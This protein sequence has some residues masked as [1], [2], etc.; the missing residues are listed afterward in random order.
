MNESA[1]DAALYDPGVTSPLLGLAVF[2]GLVFLRRERLHAALG[3]PPGVGLALL[4]GAAGLGLLAWSHAIGAQDLALPALVL[5]LVG[6]AAWLGG[7]PL[8]EALGSPL[9]ALV[10]VIQPPEV[11]LDALL[12]PLQLATVSLTSGLLSAVGRAHRVAGDLILTDG[13][14]FQVI[15][16]CSGLK[17]ITSLALA[18]VAYAELVGRRG[19]EK[20][21]LLGLT[22]AIG[23]LANGLRVLVLVFRK[24]PA[25]SV[26]H[27]VHGVAALFVGVVGLVAVE[28]GLA[29]TLFR[30]RPAG[31]PAAPGPAGGMGLA[32]RLAIGALGPVA[33]AVFAVFVPAGSLRAPETT[34]PN[35]EALPLDGDYH[36]ISATEVRSRISAGLDWESLTPSE[37]V[38]SVR[39]FFA[40]TQVR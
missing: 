28:I 1:L 23:F 33:I 24:I 32:R 3:R 12:F 25:D 29:R 9:L 6:A 4:F 17:T 40:R 11:L 10:L 19:Y 15:E 2:A 30:W 27:Q 21:V 18:A 26:E 13:V 34:P 20:A 31:S 35:I 14:A 37:I 38:E 39:D 16:G 5:L 7:R 22:P 8:V 36:E